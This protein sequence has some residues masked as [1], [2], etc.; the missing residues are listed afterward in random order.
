MNLTS[1][2]KRASAFAA[3]GLTAALLVGCSANA[4]ESG[5]ETGGDPVQGGTLRIDLPQDTSANPC[6]DPFQ[7]YGREWQL[8][9]TNLA[10][11]LVDQDTETG[12]IV[13]WLAESWDISEDGLE[14]TFNLKPDVTFSDGAV[15]DAQAVKT[16]FDADVAFAAENP[17]FGRNLEQFE[18]A[19]VTDDDTV[20][21]HLSA[22]DSSFLAKLTERSMGILSPASYERSPEERCTVG[23]ASTAAYEVEEFVPFESITFVARPDYVAT[24]ERASH[25][26]AAYLDRIELTFVNELNVR[27]GNITSGQSDVSWTRNPFTSAEVAQLISSDL[28][29]EEGS[30]T[31]LAYTY[32]P[33]TRGDRPLSDPLVREA[34]QL[35]IDRAAYAEVLYGPDY[36][37]IDGLYDADTALTSAAPGGLPA[38]DLKAAGKL[39]DEAG[40]KMGD[41]GYRANADGERLTLVALGHESN[42]LGEELLQAQ[43]RDAGIELEI[44][45][46]TVAERNSVSDAGDYD[47]TYNFSYTNDPSVIAR[48]LDTRYAGEVPVA[49]NAMSDELQQQLQANIDELLATVDTDRRK[50][51]SAEMQQDILEAGA[52]YPIYDRKQQAAVTP[53][54]GGLRFTSDGM[55]AFHD[56]WLQR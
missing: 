8:L 32:Y 36:P 12:E 47:L 42:P 31:G 30:L 39:L 40:W 18:E 5:T 33:N 56:L 15:F 54:L 34:L 25:E 20:V 6:L 41:D 19:T 21:L 28:I 11:R 23:N 22:P 53:D 14:Y 50:E 27:L 43:L 35:S 26:G 24:S 45:V 37:V 13:S 7:T 16:A 3:L 9:T 1:T 49:R 46:I 4:T 38:A 17:S 52:A 51:L 10:E 48:Q 2:L 44:R 55:L 29:I